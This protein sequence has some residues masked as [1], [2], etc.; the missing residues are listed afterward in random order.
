MHTVFKHNFM[1]HGSLTDRK[2]QS[3]A[4]DDDDDDV[5]D[6]DESKII[7]WIGEIAVKTVYK[8][9]RWKCGSGDFAALRCRLRR[10][11][12][13]TWYLFVVRV[14]EWYLWLEDTALFKLISRHTQSSV[15]RDRALR[16]TQKVLSQ[17]HNFQG[18]FAVQMH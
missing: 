15:D 8:F 3:F 6:F 12:W 9:K 1:L 7:G 2:G 13:E 17:T 18:S 10:D 5:F 14:A 4:D 16:R 11:F